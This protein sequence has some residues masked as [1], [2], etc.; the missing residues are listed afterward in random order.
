MLSTISGQGRGVCSPPLVDREEVCAEWKI[1]KRAFVREK[2]NLIENNNKLSR[3]ELMKEMES[4][5][6]YAAL[7]PEIFKL[8]K[9]LLALPVGTATV[10][11]SFSQMKLIKSRL[12]S[13][14]SD[15]NLARLLHIALKVLI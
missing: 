1:F 10:E 9:I 11:H 3:P 6:G 13:R 15:I 7:F 8:I 14:I 12:R 2:K 4:S 5:G